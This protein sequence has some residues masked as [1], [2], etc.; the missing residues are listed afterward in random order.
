MLTAL[1]VNTGGLGRFGNQCFTIAGVIGIAIKSGQPYGF[2]EWINQDNKN[3][4]DKAD[5]LNQYFV[6]PLPTIVTGVPFNH[7]G[8][9]WGYRDI[10]LPTGSWNIDAHMQSDKFTKHCMP[11]IREQFRMKDEPKQND[12]VAIHYRAGDYTEGEDGHHPRCS[13]EYYE[14]AMA[15]FPDGKFLVFTDDYD[16]WFSFGIKGNFFKPHIDN[17]NGRYIEDFRYMKRCRHFITAN[18]SFSSFAALLGEHP[19]K[20]IIQ[21]SRWFG[22]SMPPEFDTKDLYHE[23][24]III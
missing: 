10:N 12:Y 20:I 9:F 17:S 15:L 13:K 19:D 16:S 6:N 18:S 14:K 5:N 3:F 23:G 24:A 8:Y 4:G 21:P 2:P 7:Y 22:K 11:V 1:S